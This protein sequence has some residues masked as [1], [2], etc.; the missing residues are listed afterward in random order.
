MKCIHTDSFTEHEHMRTTR[1]VK[2]CA[3]TEHEHMRT[4]RNV[5]QCAYTEHEHMRTTRNV[6]QCAYTLP[7]VLFLPLPVVQ[8]L[9]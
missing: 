3:Y 6:K 7:F 4:T 1:N 9:G 8:H 2:Q 5:K